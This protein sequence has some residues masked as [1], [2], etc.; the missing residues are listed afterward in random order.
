[1]LGM[2]TVMAIMEDTVRVPSNMKMRM[3]LENLLRPDTK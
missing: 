3:K 1:M 2:E